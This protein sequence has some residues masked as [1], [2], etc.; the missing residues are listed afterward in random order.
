M[1][2]V[3]RLLGRVVQVREVPPGAQVGY[4]ATWAAS[5][6]SRVA[7]VSV[8]Y[9]DGYLRSLSRRATAFAGDRPV[10]LVGT[11]SMD[12]A[13]FDVTDAPEVREGGL[14]ELVGPRHPV[15]ALAREAGTIGYEILT[16]LGRRYARR[17]RDAD[18]SGA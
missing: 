8:G 16:S 3:V 12:T 11:V 15:D 4:G 5:R 10:P 14:L 7:T 2:P 9:A 17:Y 13:T 6:P 18:G 1:R